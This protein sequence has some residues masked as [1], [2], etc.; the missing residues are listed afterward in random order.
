MWA[1]SSVDGTPHNFHVHDVQFQVLS[2]D[3]K[4]PPPELRGWKDT[5]HPRRSPRSASPCSSAV[6]RPG[7]PYMYHCHMLNH[8]DRGLMGQF[9]VTADGR[10]PQATPAPTPHEH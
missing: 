1:V 8:E 7:D 5:V 4:E 2:I 6:P 3:G 10:T 9:V